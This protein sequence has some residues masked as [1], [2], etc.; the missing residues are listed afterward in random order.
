[1]IR[2][3]S[4]L[5]LIDENLAGP[6]SPAGL[7]QPIEILSR[8]ELHRE[9]QNRGE[10]LAL[11][12]RPPQVQENAIVLTL[13]TVISTPASTERPRAL[14]GLHVPFQQVGEEWQVTDEPIAYAT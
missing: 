9:A 14:S 8:D 10:L 13:E 1:L 7:P 2:N 4:Y 11:H 5:Y 12:F 3:Q 6:L